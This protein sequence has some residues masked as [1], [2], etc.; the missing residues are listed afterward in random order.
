MTVAPEPW[1]ELREGFVH[2]FVPCGNGKAFDVASHLDSIQIS[3]A[4]Q[5]ISV[6]N[7]DGFIVERHERVWKN[8]YTGD[9]MDMVVVFHPAP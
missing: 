9:Y 2:C 1:A 4:R 8:E 5:G 3:L 7:P 6:I